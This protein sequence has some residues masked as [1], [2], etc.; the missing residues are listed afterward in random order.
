ML[1]YFT[2]WVRHCFNAKQTERKDL[3]RAKAQSPLNPD[4]KDQ[5]SFCEVTPE[6]G[7]KVIWEDENFIAF[8]D[9]N[10]ACLQ[11]IQLIPRRHIG[12]VKELTK[13]DVE[14][15][16]SMID[17]GHRILDELCGSSATK[18]TRMGFHI[19]PF[20]SVQHLHMHIQVLPYKNWFRAKKYPISFGGGGN[21]KGFSWFVAAD[22]A[23]EILGRDKRIK[24]LPC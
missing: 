2:F 24:V 21:T 20:N 17:I 18:S 7:F 1:Q 19:P 16:K 22:Q 15:L 11:H 8:Y 9:R 14:L 12:S 23:I 5:C 4:F 3:E 10:S 6:K 13:L